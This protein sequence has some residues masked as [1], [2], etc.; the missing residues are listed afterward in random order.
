[1][2]KNPADFFLGVIK[3]K[4]VITELADKFEADMTTAVEAD[5]MQ[6]E[7][8][9][10]LPCFWTC[11]VLRQLPDKLEAD[12]KMFVVSLHSTFFQS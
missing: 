8:D 2:Y 7:G 11:T 10:L 9:N 3:T 6:L 5:G 4:E 1:M 12:A